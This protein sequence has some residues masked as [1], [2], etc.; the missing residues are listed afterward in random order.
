MA[1]KPD[2]LTKDEIA[3]LTIWANELTEYDLMRWPKKREDVIAYFRRLLSTLA[4]RTRERD[5]ALTPLP[6]T[7][8]P[9][10]TKPSVA[11]L[12][13]TQADLHVAIQ[14]AEAAEARVIELEAKWP[15]AVAWK[16]RVQQLEPW[17]ER[18]KAAERERVALRGALRKYGGHLDDCDWYNFPAPTDQCN[19]GLNAA[20]APRPPVEEE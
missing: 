11:E 7:G 8:G 12:I 17:V 20:L 3:A 18:A 6:T 16:I 14:R 4:E 13:R 5:E 1:E 19:C 15:Q 9:D 2:V 10:G